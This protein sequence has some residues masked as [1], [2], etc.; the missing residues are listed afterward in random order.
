MRCWHSKVKDFM[1]LVKSDQTV[2]EDTESNEYRGTG[3]CQRVGSVND[4]SSHHQV[5]SGQ[6]HNAQT[7]A[8][9]PLTHVQT[10][11]YVSDLT[12]QTARKGTESSGYRGTGPSER[13]G[14]V[15]DQ[16]FHH[17]RVVSG[18]LHD[19]QTPVNRPLTHVQTT[20]YVLG[21][22]APDGLRKAP[23]VTDIVVRD[24]VSG[25]ARLMVNRTTTGW[26]R[27]SFTMLKH[28]LHGRSPPC[29][30]SEADCLL[31]LAHSSPTAPVEQTREKVRACALIIAFLA[32]HA[33]IL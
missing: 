16:S 4:R 22:D 5:V 28:P 21:F 3:P 19:A 32:L 31:P 27:G 20:K 9:R 10:T 25:S 2:Q 6:L 15:N 17:Y 30:H 14:S 24:Q 1:V 33:Y 7:L 29:R 18:Q 13:V 12:H 8:N 11:K 26:C 23:G